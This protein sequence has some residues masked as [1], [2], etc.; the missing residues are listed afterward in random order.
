MVDTSSSHTYLASPDQPDLPQQYQYS[1]ERS[2]DFSW[3]NCIDTV[4]CNVCFSE[5]QC[6][7]E[8]ACEQTWYMAKDTIC[9]DHDDCYES[10]NSDSESQSDESEGSSDESDESDESEEYQDGDNY[11]VFGYNLK[12]ERRERSSH[13]FSMEDQNDDIMM[14]GILSLNRETTSFIQQLYLQNQDVEHQFAHYF[15]QNNGYL[16][17]ADAVDQLLDLLN[18]EDE[19][20]SW[21]PYYNQEIPAMYQVRLEHIELINAFE[22]EVIFDDEP[23]ENLN[24]LTFDTAMSGIA[25]NE[26]WEDE[27]LT[28]IEE[29]SDVTLIRTRYYP[30]CIDTNSDNVLND[31]YYKL[32]EI[33]ISLSTSKL[34]YEFIISPEQYV[35]E[36]DNNTV[37]FPFCLDISFDWDD[38]I[39]L[40]SS[41]MN[42]Y[43]IIYN[44][45]AEAIGIY[46][47][48]LNHQRQQNND[49]NYDSFDLAEQEKKYVFA[50]SLAL[51][52]VLI[53]LLCVSGI[54]V[55]LLRKRNKQ[56]EGETGRGIRTWNQRRKSV[57][58]DAGS[59]PRGNVLLSPEHVAMNS[60]RK[61]HLELDSRSSNVNGSNS[62]SRN[63]VNVSMSS[64]VSPFG[65]FYDGNVKSIVYDRIIQP[66]SLED[67]MDAI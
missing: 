49:E 4:Y 52:A 11:L 61:R 8:F 54:C 37:D 1:N 45:D 6:G 10:D 41:T 65:S 5:S 17:I 50:L 15:N 12:S 13:V 27:V 64:S 19:D 33:R 46:D 26:E 67:D 57:T 32:P 47:K 48:N 30:Y 7:W 35:V 36:M 60:K 38:G 22:N 51:V 40:G 9:L 53:C 3:L 23:T 58:I 44:E 28:F 39:C 55:Y 20:L 29:K 63:E 59:S 2:N 42:N 14:G 43:I 25:I 16:A 56:T 31:I 66:Y 18:I 24:I 34:G 62:K 21:I